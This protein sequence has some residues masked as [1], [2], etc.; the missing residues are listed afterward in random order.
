MWCR[1]SS[2]GGAH[3]GPICNF[4]ALPVDEILRQPKRPRTK[5]EVDRKQKRATVTMASVATTPSGS[6]S[7]MNKYYSYKIGGLNSVS[8]RSSPCWSAFFESTGGGLLGSSCTHNQQLLPYSYPYF[9]HTHP[10]S[11][12]SHRQSPN[13]PLTSN[14]SKHGA[15]N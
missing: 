2:V 4:R 8:V 15:T 7:G 3:G 6:S 13:A 10:I 11:F 12:I 5:R 14:V 9:L 1:D